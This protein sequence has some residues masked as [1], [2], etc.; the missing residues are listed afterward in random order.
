[1]IVLVSYLARPALA[2]SLACRSAALD[3][4]SISAVNPEVAAD[5]TEEMLSL[6]KTCGSSPQAEGPNLVFGRFKPGGNLNSV[7]SEKVISG[8]MSEEDLS[9]PTKEGSNV[10]KSSGILTKSSGI[11]IPPVVTRLVWPTG[12]SCGPRNE[13][14]VGL[15]GTPVM[16]RPA[17]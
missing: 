11:R 4:W 2:V 1:M 14:E 16:R 6:G 5:P 10:G 13:I 7:A 17:G 12:K 8:L 15:S 3:R 9:T